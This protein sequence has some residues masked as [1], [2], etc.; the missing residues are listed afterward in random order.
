MFD[1]LEA[2]EKRYEELTEKITDIS[3]TF[4]LT[5]LFRRKLTEKLL[6]KFKATHLHLTQ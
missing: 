6:L 2:V 5:M 4:S 1:K 3:I